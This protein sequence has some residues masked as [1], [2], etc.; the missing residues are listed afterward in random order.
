MTVTI[1]VIGVGLGVPL[2]FI[3][4]NVAW[5]ELAQSLDVASDLVVPVGLVA[6]C[7][8]VAVAAGLAAAALPTWRATH[9]QVAALLRSE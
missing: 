1:V 4:A 3:A 2:G 6:L 8:P 7:L 9:L 5:R